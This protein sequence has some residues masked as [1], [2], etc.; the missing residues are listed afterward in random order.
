MTK[1][2]RPPRVAAT[3]L[4]LLNKSLGKGTHELTLGLA[5]NSA[6][7]TRRSSTTWRVNEGHCSNTRPTAVC[8][9]RTTAVVS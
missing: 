4:D 9:D 3:L 8:A 2:V 5:V 7:E 6:A 1:G